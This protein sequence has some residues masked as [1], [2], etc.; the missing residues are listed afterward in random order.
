MFF[1]NITF[2]RILP[3]AIENT[4]QIKE[5]VEKLLYSSLLPLEEVGQGWYPVAPGKGVVYSSGRHVLLCARLA[6][7]IL[8]S[9]VLKEKTAKAIEEIE[10]KQG[11]AIGKK[12]KT[13]IKEQIRL[14][15][16][17][18]A[19]TSEKNI[20]VWINFA[21]QYIAINTTTKSQLDTVIT[22]LSKTLTSSLLIPYEVNAPIRSYLGGLLFGDIGVPDSFNIENTFIVES[23]DDQKL[24]VNYKNYELNEVEVEKHINAGLVVSLLGI[25]WKDRIYFMLLDSFTLQIKGVEPLNKLAEDSEQA[26]FNLD[27][28]SDAFNVNFFM[29]TKEID[30]LRADLVKELGGLKPIDILSE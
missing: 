15:L 12:H 4:E 18:Q 29:M 30:E 19:F 26:N 16:L 9:S 22:L 11:R 24:K 2:F 21:E 13:E 10:Q 20:H 25:T 6:K 7:K 28:E 1:K 3:R 5:A 23:N 17:K 27:D 14:S 8:P